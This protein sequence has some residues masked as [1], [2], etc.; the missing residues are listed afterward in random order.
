MTAISPSAWTVQNII[1]PIRMY[2][3]NIEPG[4][5]VANALPVPTKR[6]VPM[7]PPIAIIWRCRPFRRRTSGE[8][9]VA[10]AAASASNSR[11]LPA[12]LPPIL[13]RVTDALG[14]RRNESVIRA[15]RGLLTSS[16]A[17]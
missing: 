9:A 8:A 15:V 10:A 13:P 12:L 3:I 6:P 1:T 11:F 16:V 7:E 2:A 14:S 4:P 5:P 17:P